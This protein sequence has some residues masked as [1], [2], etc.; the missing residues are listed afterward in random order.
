MGKYRSWID[1]DW[2][3]KGRGALKPRNKRR[4]PQWLLEK[5]ER[6]G[7]ENRMES[8]KE[9]DGMRDDGWILNRSKQAHWWQQGATIT[10]SVGLNPTWATAGWH[11]ENKKTAS[12]AFEG[13]YTPEGAKQVLKQ[14]LFF[15]P[16]IHIQLFNWSSSFGFQIA[17]MKAHW[18]T[19]HDI[20]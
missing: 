1:G 11:V 14:Y 8:R 6:G 15:A 20:Q 9:W 17:I 7:K 5:W 10:L 2:Q 19:I 4:K 18:R 12:T 16:Y 3:L 13:L